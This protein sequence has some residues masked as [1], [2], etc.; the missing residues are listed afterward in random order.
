MV[1]WNALITLTLVAAF[2]NP[3]SVYMATCQLQVVITNLIEEVRL[4]KRSVASVFPQLLLVSGRLIVLMVLIIANCILGE[5]IS[6]TDKTVTTTATAIK[7]VQQLAHPLPTESIQAVVESVKEKID[8]PGIPASDDHHDGI[9]DPPPVDTQSMASGT[10]DTLENTSECS[11]KT[12][13]DAAEQMQTSALKGENGNSDRTVVD[14]H[15][16]KNSELPVPLEG[17]NRVDP[18]KNTS[19]N[20]TEAQQDVPPQQQSNSQ[21]KRRS[22]LL[23]ELKPPRQSMEKPRRKFSIVQRTNETSDS[24][25]KRL[26]SIFKKR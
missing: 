17:I 3:E 11:E 8:I 2:L 23:P 4:K 6:K 19:E 10:D 18:S 21:I 9:I 13:H 12:E 16:I 1:L 25:P 22:L 5:T 24:K 26:L 20:V 15:D 7:Q 14:P